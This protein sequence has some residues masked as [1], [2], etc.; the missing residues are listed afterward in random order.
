MVLFCL[1]DWLCPILSNSVLSVAF[2]SVRVS[3]SVLPMLLCSVLSESVLSMVLCQ[4]MAMTLRI[5]LVCLC[6]FVLF[7]L[8][9]FFPPD[10]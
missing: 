9:A 1:C 6:D 3:G 10:D 5:V 8:S 4:F 2:C 7:R